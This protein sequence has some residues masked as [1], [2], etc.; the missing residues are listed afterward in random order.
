MFIMEIVD[1]FEQMIGVSPGQRQ[2]HSLSAD[3]LQSSFRAIFHQ[4][5]HFVLKRFHSIQGIFGRKQGCKK[6]NIGSDSKLKP[7]LCEY[8]PFKITFEKWFIF[9]EV[10]KF[11]KKKIPDALR[12]HNIWRDSDGRECGK[13]PLLLQSSKNKENNFISQIA[14]LWRRLCALSSSWQ[15]WLADPARCSLCKRLQ[16]FPMLKIK[17][18][19]NNSGEYISKMGQ[20]ISVT[21]FK[22]YQNYKNWNLP[23]FQLISFTSLKSHPRLPTGSI[24][25]AQVW[26]HLRTVLGWIS[27]S[28]RRSV[29]VQALESIHDSGVKAKYRTFLNY[30]YLLFNHQIDLFRSCSQQF[31]ARFWLRWFFL[32][33]RWFR[34]GAWESEMKTFLI[35]SRYNFQKIFFLDLENFSSELFTSSRQTAERVGSFFHPQELRPYWCILSHTWK[36][37]KIRLFRE[38]LKEKADLEKL[39]IHYIRPFGIGQVLHEI[40][41]ILSPDRHVP[42]RLKCL[43]WKQKIK[44]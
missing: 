22:K 26:M 38:K 12:R 7:D 17:T 15:R 18:Y 13:C 8:F 9:L 20:D 35:E 39:I 30:K 19:F 5:A 40:E 44:Q 25:K 37:P 1:S 32:T 27:P 42:P 4:N 23:T 34:L 29:S 41:C 36:S 43:I 10:A 6:F 33:D 2:V 28:C 24:E 21:I 3:S 11:L 16:T 31:P 14:L